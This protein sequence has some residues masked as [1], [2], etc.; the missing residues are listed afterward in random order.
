MP[1]VFIS[2]STQDRAF[3]EKEILRLLESCGVE[4]WYSQ[5]SIAATDQWERSIL[6]GLR[7]CDAFLLVMSPHSA[8]SPWVKREVDW[9]FQKGGKK[10]IPLLIEDCDTDDFHIGLVSIQHVDFSKDRDLGRQALLKIGGRLGQPAKGSGEPAQLDRRRTATRSADQAI[11]AELKRPA[12]TA[13]TAHKIGDV[14]EVPLT[15]AL[16]MRFAW[17]PPGTSWLRGGGGKPG[18][19]KFTLDKGLWCGVYPVTQ[20]EWQA[21]MGDNPSHFKNKPRHPVESVSW[22][23]VQEFLTALNAKLRESGLA[24]RL[25][26]GE[27]WEYIC[28][29]GPCCSP[30]QSKYH[31][32][33]AKSKTDLTP[34]PTNALSS[35]Q[36]NFD[37]RHPIGLLNEWFGSNGPYLQATSEVGSYLPNPL[38]IYDLHG[39]VWEWTSL[40]FNSGS[41]ESAAGEGWDCRG[42]NCPDSVLRVG[43]GNASFL[44][45]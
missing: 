5:D 30:D 2:H 43:S 10:I 24:Y 13:Q 33:F 41:G 6:Q 8:Q 25:P 40:K 14:I 35:R 34:A 9:I 19:W 37:G 11:G 16:K 32:Y 44:Q 18:E 27:E 20:A 1:K 39:N 3:V 12:P 31:F 42:V 36:A 28:R 38:G 15:S 4:T 23:R 29:G 26:T 17:V 22:D 45:N 21:V 7:T